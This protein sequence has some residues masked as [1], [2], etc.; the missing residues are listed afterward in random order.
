MLATKDVE[1]WQLAKQ[2]FIRL[3]RWM[4]QKLLLNNK[5]NWLSLTEHWVRDWKKKLHGNFISDE[6]M[7]VED[8]SMQLSTLWHKKLLIRSANEQQSR[9]QLRSFVAE[10]ESMASRKSSNRNNCLLSFAR[11][12]QWSTRNKWAVQLL[13]S[14]RGFTSNTTKRA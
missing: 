12:V 7:F 11:C 9:K 6:T 10:V 1:L 5:S 13:C 8:I 3:Q 2:K 14:T 4:K